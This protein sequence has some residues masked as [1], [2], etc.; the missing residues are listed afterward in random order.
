MSD[1]TNKTTEEMIRLVSEKQEALRSFRFAMT[2]SK[3]KNVKEGKAIR[4]EVARI[5]TELNK[6]QN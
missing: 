1:Y 4:K 5:L 3:K 2:G 6:M